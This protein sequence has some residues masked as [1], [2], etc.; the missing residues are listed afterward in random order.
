MIIYSKSFLGGQCRF[1]GSEDALYACS[2]SGWID[3][4]LFMAWLKKIFFKNVV[5]E[6]PALLLT[7]GHKSHI[8]LDVI[9]LC[10]ENNY[11]TFLFTT[12]HYACIAATRCGGVLRTVLLSPSGLFLSQ[13]RILWLQRVNFLV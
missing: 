10:R 1:D 2:E 4:E 3:S 6:S 11:H 12:P 5:P 7:D 9:D 8:N 13:R